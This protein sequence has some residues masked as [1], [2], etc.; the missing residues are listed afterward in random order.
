MSGTLENV[1]PTCGAPFRGQAVCPRCGTDLA[2]LMRVLVQAYRLRLS[3]R[4][5]LDSGNAAMAETLAARAVQLHRTAEGISLLAQA[6]GAGLPPRMA[7]PL[8][9]IK[10]QR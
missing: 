5:S 9:G 4:A 7:A 3:A 1:C 2:P 6:R 10:G 8:G